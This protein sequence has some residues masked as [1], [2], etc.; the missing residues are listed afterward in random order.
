MTMI[1]S[2]VKAIDNLFIRPLPAGKPGKVEKAVRVNGI[3]VF[4]GST[5]T[6]YCDAMKPY[7]YCPGIYPWTDGLMRALEKLHVITAE[8]RKEHI[9]RCE[10]M[11][12]EA[13]K[14]WRWKH[15]LECSQKYGFKVTAE[16]KRKLC[17]EGD[18]GTE[19][20]C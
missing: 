15:L 12:K 4:V 17:P 3:T 16:Q 7:A 19:A 5:G 10:E 20:A 6:L 9:R 18:E 11:D 1:I 8:Q 14:K 2:H 13:D